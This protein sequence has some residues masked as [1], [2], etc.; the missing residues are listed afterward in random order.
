M[1]TFKLDTIPGE[2]GFWSSSTEKSFKEMN[3]QLIDKGFTEEGAF[4]FLDKA[5]WA[6]AGEF[7][8]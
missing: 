4:D 5:Y 7:G 2:E 3:K 1:F 6:V 8:S